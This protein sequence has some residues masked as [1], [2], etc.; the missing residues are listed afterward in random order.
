VHPSR[1]VRTADVA[2]QPWRNGGGMTRTLLARP[3]GEH[4]RVRVSVADVEV[5]GPFS[6]FP[7]VERWF[8]VLDGAGVVLTIRNKEHRLDA[9]D[10]ALSFPGEVPVRC[11]LLAGATRDLNLML[12]GVP[13]SMRRVVAAEPWRPGTSEC[14]LYATTAGHCD[15]CG[16]DNREAMPPHALRW[17]PEAPESLAFDGAGWWLSADLP[18]AS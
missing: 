16:P 12:S 3:G 9:G 18:P 4:W 7:G 2:A 13:G 17:W 11:R 1:L 5:N 6:R 8:A 15:A 10:E 14:G